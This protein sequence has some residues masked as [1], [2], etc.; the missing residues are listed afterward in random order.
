M[1]ESLV[2]SLDLSKRLVEAGVRLDTEFYWI[3]FFSISNDKE[4]SWSGEWIVRSYQGIGIP[5]DVF[6]PWWKRYKELVDMRIPAPLTD[7]L[8][9]VVKGE[10]K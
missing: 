8:L 3:P 4:I 7:E 9:A 6:K 5:E 2:L 10:R 1:N